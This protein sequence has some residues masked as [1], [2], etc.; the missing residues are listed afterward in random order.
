MMGSCSEGRG[1]STA[2]HPL[3]R[4]P[5]AAADIRG[6]EASSGGERALAPRRYDGDPPAT[7]IFKRAASGA[8]MKLLASASAAFLLTLG[9]GV[10]FAC[11]Q[12][13]SPAP[14]AVKV[15]RADDVDLHYIERGT[16]VPVVF[17]H[18]W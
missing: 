9:G 3:I 8:L 13:A 5:T 15:V 11:A 16:G 6:A 7:A 1:L 4:A 2:S 14:Q 10:R 12:S 18:G 17:V